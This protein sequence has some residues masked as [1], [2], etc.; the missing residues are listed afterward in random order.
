MPKVLLVVRATVLDA[1]ER[2]SFDDWYRREHLP[3]A[4]RA[5][6]VKKA[7]RCWSAD[8]HSV[9]LATYQFADNDA[10]DRV[11]GGD[12]IKQL[13]AEFSRAWPEVT[14]TREILVMAEEWNGA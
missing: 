12:A 3:D 5:F 13:T 4:V 1:S 2:A 8:D 10:L 7:W 14:R 6:G 9:H 11:T